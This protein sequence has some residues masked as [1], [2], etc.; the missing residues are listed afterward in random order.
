MTN[1]E[2]FLQAKTKDEVASVIFEI[3]T[4]ILYDSVNFNID[5]WLDKEY[6]P[7]ETI[8]KGL[9]LIIENRLKDLPFS[10]DKSDKE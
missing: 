1:Y 8:T 10:Q 9:K 6:D 3:E 7:K 2:N 4:E 5:R